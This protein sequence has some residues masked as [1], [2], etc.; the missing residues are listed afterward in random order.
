MEKEK[1]I[2]KNAMKFLA[3]ALALLLVVA[4]TVAY[5]PM[6]GIVLKANAA[7]AGTINLSV[8]QNQTVPSD[9]STITCY[10]YK[11]NNILQF[12]PA[13]LPTGAETSYNNRLDSAKLQTLYDNGNLTVSGNLTIE[14]LKANFYGFVL[15]TATAYQLNWS[16]SGGRTEAFPDGSFTLKQG[17]E[18]PIIVSGSNVNVALDAT[19]TFT[20]SAGPNADIWNTVHISKVYEQEVTASIQD[21]RMNLWGNGLSNAST[22]IAF[23]EPTKPTSY[24]AVHG[25]SISEDVYNQYVHFAGLTY[26]EFRNAGAD[27]KFFLNSAL[28]GIQIVWGDLNDGADTVKLQTGDNIIFK[29]GFPVTYTGD[30]YKYTASLDADYVF[31]VVGKNAQNDQTFRGMK[32]ESAGITYNVTL[33]TRNNNADGTVNIGITFASGAHDANANYDNQFACSIAEEYVEF[34]NGSFDDAV[35]AGIGL[36][37]IG[38]SN[39]IQLVYPTQST[40]ILAVGEAVI[41]KDGMPLYYDN[42]TTLSAISLVGNYYIERTASGVKMST[43][44]GTFN[45]NTTTSYKTYDE[46]VGGVAH[47][48]ARLDYMSGNFAD[49]SNGQLTVTTT[50][51]SAVD[52]ISVNGVTGDALLNK[53]YF[54]NTYKPANTFLRLYAPNGTF[55]TTVGSTIILKQGLPFTYTTTESVSKTVILDKDYGYTFNGTNWVYDATITWPEEPEEPAGL[56]YGLTTNPGASNNGVEGPG[57]FFQSSITGDQVTYPGSGQPWGDVTAADLNRYVDFSHCANAE[58]VKA[59]TTVRLVIA[60]ATTR[61]LRVFFNDTALA[62]LQNG[63]YI[64]L[65]QNMPITLSTGE[66][67]LLDRDY[68]VGIVSTNPVKV[69]YTIPAGDFAMNGSHGYVITKETPNFLSFTYASGSFANKIDDRETINFSNVQSHIEVQNKTAAELS[70]NGW[71]FRL[72]SESKEAAQLRLCYNTLGMADGDIILLKKGLPITYT[73]TDGNYRTAHLDKTYGYTLSGTNLLYDAGL[74]A[75]PVPNI[76]TDH[77]GSMTY[78]QGKDILYSNSFATD[79]TGIHFESTGGS[80]IV[81]DGML[82][83]EFE[84]NGAGYNIFY[85]Q[86]GAIAGHEYIASYY[87]YVS[88]ASSIELALFDIAAAS[89]GYTAGPV[90]VYDWA[91]HKH[92]NRNDYTLTVDGQ[93]MSSAFSTVHEGWHHVELKW[94]APADGKFRFGLLSND[95]TKNGTATVYIDD[96][97]VYDNT[98]NPYLSAENKGDVTLVEGEWHTVLDNNDATGKHTNFN[99]TSGSMANV[100]ATAYLNMDLGAVENFDFFGLTVAEAKAYGVN[101]RF[102]KDGDGSVLVLQIQWGNSLEHLDNGGQF[103][104]SAGTYYYEKNGTIY[105]LTLTKGVTLV[106]EMVPN[107][108]SASASIYVIPDGMTVTDYDYNGDGELTDTDKRLMRMHLCG[109]FTLS[110]PVETLTL[111]NSIR[112][113][114]NGIMENHPM[115]QTIIK[116]NENMNQTRFGYTA[117]GK[118][119]YAGNNN[120][121]VTHNIGEYNSGMASITNASGANYL[122]GGSMTAYINYNGSEKS[123]SDL[124]DGSNSESFLESYSYAARA[125]TVVMGQHYSSSYVRD[126]VWSAGSKLWLEKGFHTY[127]DKMHQAYRVVAEGAVNN[128]NAFGIELVLPEEKVVELRVY[129]G[130]S[131]SNDPTEDQTGVWCVAAKIANVGVIGLIMNGDDPNNYITVNDSSDWVIRQYVVPN[132]LAAGEDATVAHRLY[133]DSSDNFDGL[134]AALAV[135]RNPLNFSVDSTDGAGGGS[136]NYE[137]G[138][139][140]FDIDG[141]KF[142]EAANNPDKKFMANISVDGIDDRTVYLCVN[143]PNPLE[144][145]AVLDHNDVQLPIPMQVNKNFG[146]EDEEPIYAPEADEGQDSNDFVYGETYMPLYL[147]T[148]N[149][150][151]EFTIINAMQNW[152]NFRLKQ[153]SS[154]SYFTSYYHLSTGVMETNCIAPFSTGHRGGMEDESPTIKTHGIAWLLPDFRGVSG[155]HQ[156]NTNTG[157]RDANQSNSVGTVFAPSTDKGTTMDYYTGSAIHSSGLTYADLTMTYTANNGN[158]KYTMRHMEMPQEDESRTYYSIEFEILKDCTLTNDN[159]NIMAIGSRGKEKDYYE[160]ATFLNASGQEQTVTPVTSGSTA[161]PLKSGSSYFT[162]YKLS[163]ENQEDGNAAIIVKDY[164]ITQNGAASNT[165]LAFLNTYKTVSDTEWSKINYGALVLNGNQSFKVGDKIKIDL[166]VLAYGKTVQDNYDN[167]KRVYEDS[168][169]NPITISAPGYSVVADPFIPTVVSKNNVAEFTLSGGYSAADSDRANIATN[170]T[171][172]VKGFDRLQA[173]V[174][175]EK[176]NGKWVEY[177]YN[178]AATFDGYSVQYENGKLTYSFVVAMSGSDRTFRVSMKEPVKSTSLNFTGTD[179]NGFVAGT[180]MNKTLNDDGTLTL[181]TTGGD[182]VLYNKGLYLD[183]PESQKVRITLKIDTYAS[184]MQFNLGVYGDYLKNGVTTKATDFTAAFIQYKAISNQEGYI[185]LEFDLTKGDTTV[186]WL[187][188]RGLRLGINGAGGYEKTVTIQSIEIVK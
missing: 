108:N 75:I 128:L 51:P 110:E 66:V 167:V 13:D 100:D 150:H 6:T 38:N 27:I 138:F 120:V 89:A 58:T 69:S 76:P 96:V 1:I 146:H 54:L 80:N 15:A 45:L 175:Y 30:G 115:L 185:T 29:K 95:S 140:D 148:K 36:K 46:N 83:L 180:D 165:G 177:D 113:G 160:K 172:K 102:I 11:S 39:V 35:A 97:L 169:T 133:T 106:R 114:D 5:F 123:E 183:A 88:K 131:Y 127:S 18:L 104:L 60:S 93:P 92:T 40:D 84:G 73:D 22:N 109:V 112:K 124:S 126:Q 52:Y 151:Q 10:L 91:L 168:V 71:Y 103:K 157:N 162:F 94:T 12:T 142:S 152:G 161:Y 158:Y 107:H 186:K 173:P 34:S 178:N 16:A 31:Q 61:L 44:G 78:P 111:V 21:S 24:T 7:S 82:K 19:Y 64:T 188:I 143:T 122:D 117:D 59:G 134:E 37:Y 176:V 139:Y 8:I 81:E 74:T 153:V 181:S 163:D 17:T 179:L 9:G 28:F 67:T 62:A 87:I 135:E 2:V 14:D 147:T 79:S 65:K 118:A 156:Y 43:Y 125:K 174:I 132:S 42:G 136:Y 159:F 49:M 47:Q 98:Y 26:E 25:V 184:G 141:Y 48:Y 3:K 68:E 32:Y 23:D 90:N 154:I 99:M 86:T 55:P 33:G 101:I 105:A 129:S 121:T 53:G 144:G 182:N 164:S 50:N 119:Y 137:T 171:V 187:K 85:D 155:D 20:F 149:P 72:L 77:T 166:V 170:Y 116:S 70:A 41:L 57:T 63:D 130:D 145:A 56:V 4:M